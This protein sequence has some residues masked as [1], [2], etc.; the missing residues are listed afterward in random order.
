M[1]LSS[2]KRQENSTKG[3]EKPTEVE[4]DAAREE[5]KELATEIP[6]QHHPNI[7]VSYTSATPVQQQQVS[8][9]PSTSTLL[10]G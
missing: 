3:Q 1:K 7:C 2:G 5:T 8:H 4:E 10:E 9:L 6:L